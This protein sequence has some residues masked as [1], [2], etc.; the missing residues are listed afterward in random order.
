MS[1]TQLKIPRD[2][3]EAMRLVAS[4]RNLSENKTCFDCGQ[5]APSWCSVNNGVFLCMDCCGR[6][7]GMGVHLSFMRSAE[8]DDWTP[9][10]AVSMALGGN[11]AARQYYKQNGIQ[12]T[13]NVYGTSVALQ[14]RKKL[15]AEV[16]STMQEGTLPQPSRVQ[17]SASPS[18]GHVQCSSTSV[19]VE[20]ALL[21][22]P[23]SRALV[24]SPVSESVTPISSPNVN[25]VPISSTPGTKKPL[26]SKKKGLGGARPAEVVAEV[27]QVSEIPEGRLF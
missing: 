7:R 25:V 16:R 10:Q 2:G 1:K 18:S 20:Q 9:T 17:H 11:A 15:E 13:K 26:K 4:L 3:D 27:A 6:H 23:I 12:D 22:S 19:Q 5:K 24:G 8:L 14:Y 21:E